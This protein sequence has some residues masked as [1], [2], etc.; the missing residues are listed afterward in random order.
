MLFYL[1]LK[2]KNKLSFLLWQEDQK[3]KAKNASCLTRVWG[4]SGGD[5]GGERRRK[6]W[7][8]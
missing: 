7:E 6:E 2:I 1:K 5:E 3:N 8:T 4:R